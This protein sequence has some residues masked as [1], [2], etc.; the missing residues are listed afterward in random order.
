MTKEEPVRMPQMGE[1]IAEGTVVKWHKKVGEKVRRDETLF[2]ISTDKVDTEVPSPC[3]GRLA[4][5]LVK[6]GETVPVHTV[7][8]ILGTG[9]GAA[10][11]AASANAKSGSSG[12]LPLP[13]V[14]PGA[15]PSVPASGPTAPEAATSRAD[16]L[17]E[18]SSPLVRRLA[19]EKGIDIK[20]L[21]G[22]GTGGRVTKEDLLQHI[23]RMEQPAPR[24]STEDRVEP[25][26][27]MRQRIA[28][29]MIASRRAS[30]HVSSIFEVDMTVVRKLKDSRAAEYETQHKTKL[31]YLPFVLQ[32]V[33][34][35]LRKHP[36]LNASIEGKNVRYH[37]EVHLG[38][39]VAL[40]DG[41][42]VPVV[43][44][45][46]S[47]DLP[48]LAKVVSDLAQRARSKQLKPEEV[49]GGTFTVTNPGVFGSLI[50][51]PIISQP[52]VAILCIGAIT[53]RPVVL[54]ESDSIAIRSMVFLSLSFDH[55]L[56]DGAVAD[57]FMADVKNQL[58]S[59]AF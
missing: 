27:P 58:E 29:H 11:D 5:V 13:T 8:C 19:A 14:S 47:K 42:I 12:V 38:V 3:D 44:Q 40:D 37:G 4:E 21:S 23:A 2:E 6:E 7:V 25:M 28:E 53:K 41:L 18:L 55:R 20:T 31:T 36:K 50:G 45:A 51:T 56:V 1:S 43:R 16:R 30:A 59:G 26:T 32:A 46:D 24:V 15:Q 54:A 9:D 34:R 52:Q 22:S 35:A 49:Q 17:R 39:A 33:A 57:R 48:T 10:N